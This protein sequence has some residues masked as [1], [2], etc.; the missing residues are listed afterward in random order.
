MKQKPTKKHGMCLFVLTNYFWVWLANSTRI[1]RRASPA[2]FTWLSAL[3]L[4]CSNKAWDASLPH[5]SHCVYSNMLAEMSREF[6]LLVILRS[7]MTSQGQ[8]NLKKKNSSL[9]KIT[10]SLN[11]QISQMQ[12]KKSLFLILI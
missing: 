9:G 8:N 3:F 2:V 4:C 7:F 5:V 6:L 10:E 1:P 12:K 11:I